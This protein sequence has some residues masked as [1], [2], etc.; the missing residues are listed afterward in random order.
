MV[1]GYEV[2]VSASCGISLYPEHT[3]NIEA[4]LINADGA[5][6]A[7][8]KTAGNKAILFDEKISI[9]KKEKLHIEARLKKA[10]ALEAI[11]VYYQPK[12]DA[13]TNKMT[14]VEALLRW[15]DEELG[16]VSPDRF[17][18]VAEDAGL[19]HS[20]WKI[21]MKKACLQVTKWNKGR[22]EPLTLAVNFSAKQFQEPCSLVKQVKEFLSE[23]GLAPELFEIEITESTLLFNTKETIRALENLHQYGI[24]IS[25][26]DFGT[27]YSSLS[28]LKTLPI[29]SLKI[30]RSFIQDIGDDF[31]DSEIAEAIINLARSLRL[32]VIAEGVEEEYQKEFLMQHHCYDMQGYLFSKPVSAE[33]LGGSWGQVP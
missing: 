19:V 6:Y 31:R 8:K 27:G 22:E 2:G 28:Y 30:D 3:D 26:D 1:D 18:A 5:M 33:E 24:S 13:R 9:E 32:K 4:L 29:T 10:I 15:T 12:V 7:A 11:D 23:C 16:F 17:I 14:G 25:I 21:A 20:L